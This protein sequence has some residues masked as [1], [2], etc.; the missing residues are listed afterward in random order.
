MPFTP[1]RRFAVLS[2][3]TYR[4]YMANPKREWLVLIVVPAL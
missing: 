3:L 4:S 1:K 2:V